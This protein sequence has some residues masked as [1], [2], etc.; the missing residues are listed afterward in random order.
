MDGSECLVG[1]WEPGDNDRIDNRLQ[2]NSFKV[3]A[4][5]WQ[6]FVDVV[7]ESV[8]LE[9]N[10]YILKIVSMTGRMNLCSTSITP[11]K[12]DPDPDVEDEDEDED[13]IIHVPGHFS[14]MY[15]AD[16]TSTTQHLIIWVTV[17]I[18]RIDQW[19]QRKT[20]IRYAINQSNSQDTTNIAI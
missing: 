3:P 5:G 10:N 7:W 6:K 16:K 14:A 8:D 19:M 12:A 20:R 1:W 15:Y 9:P 2:S 13:Y 4:K 18:G 11:T 17:H